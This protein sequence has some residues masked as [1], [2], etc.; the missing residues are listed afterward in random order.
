MF[1]TLR[2]RGRGGFWQLSRSLSWVLSATV[3]VFLSSVHVPLF[4]QPS[5]SLIIHVPSGISYA[6][7]DNIG[8]LLWGNGV[9]GWVE[10][11]KIRLW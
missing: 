11:I 6:R 2:G 10:R 7:V 5:T 1:L 4:I 8:G 9:V 3:Q